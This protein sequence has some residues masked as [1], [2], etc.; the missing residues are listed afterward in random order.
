MKENV[1]W[2]N[3]IESTMPIKNIYTLLLLAVVFFGYGQEYPCGKR[4]YGQIATSSKTRWID[5]KRKVRRGDT[6]TGG[7][8]SDLVSFAPKYRATVINSGD[9][10]AFS[11]IEPN[12]LPSDAKIHWEIVRQFE[13]AQG[14]CPAI[15]EH[16]LRIGM[17]NT[18]PITFTKDSSETCGLFETYVV[19]LY[20]GND[21]IDCMELFVLGSSYQSYTN[22]F[23]FAADAEQDEAIPP[24]NKGV[25]YPDFSSEFINSSCSDGPIREKIDDKSVFTTYND[26]SVA[27]RSGNPGV[28]RMT[29]PNS[30]DG[31]LSFCEQ[32]PPPW[33]INNRSR[34]KRND[35]IFYPRHI[36]GSEYYYQVSIM[37]PTSN[38]PSF[39]DDFYNIVFEFHQSTFPVVALRP[40]FKAIMHLLINGSN[41][42]K[43]NYGLVGIGYCASQDIPYRPGE[44]IDFT[45]H[46][47]WKN[48]YQKPAGQSWSTDGSDGLFECWYDNNKINF[49]QS[50]VDKYKLTSGFTGGTTIYGPNL[51]NYNPA[52]IVFNQYRLRRDSDDDYEVPYESD[53]L[54]DDFIITKDR[55]ASLS[56]PK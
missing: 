7:I 41:K 13:N 10:V 9:A 2:N 3:G 12:Y 33:K 4:P 37:V 43:I 42:M 5:V 28:L 15:G 32:N 25:S 48:V 27:S 45:F 38:D 40:H 31:S 18:D 50:K 6:A 46:I 14:L 24:R 30:S 44:W 52:N 54:F 49:T 22:H 36:E 47:K 34:N 29:S 56:K 55:P 8:G 23:D 19:N 20:E 51:D 35:V 11:L 17:R 21:L 1:E 26:I 16:Y 39:Y 53:V